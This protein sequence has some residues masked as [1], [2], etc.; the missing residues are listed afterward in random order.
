MIELSHVTKKYVGKQALCDV[1]LT[2]PCGEIVGLLGENGAGKTTLMKCIL[3]FVRFEGTITLDGEPIT[4][5]NIASLSFGTSE[6]SFFPGLTAQAHREFYEAHFPCFSAQ[7]FHGL[8]DFFH[9]PLHQPLRAFSTGQK[10]QFEV[11]LALSQGADYI[12]LDE[13]FAAL[14]ALS[15]FAGT[16]IPAPL[17]ALR[18]REERFRAVVNKDEMRES[19]KK[20]LV[21]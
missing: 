20:W 21:K 18:A 14:D 3:G 7:R 17:D 12:L 4:H 10:N 11:I 6:H 5:R 8:M 19:V 2:L 13:P 9:L 15:A 16:P 1:S